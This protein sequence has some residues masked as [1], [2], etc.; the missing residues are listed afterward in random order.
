MRKMLAC[1]G[2]YPPL[3]FCSIISIWLL[4]AVSGIALCQTPDAALGTGDEKCSY[5]PEQ[6]MQLLSVLGDK[7]GYSYDSLLVDLSRWKQSPYVSIDSL[8]ATV[9]NR[10]LWELTIT[11]D[12]PAAVPRRTVYVHA[13]T[14]P[15]EVQAFWVTD[16][17]IKLLLSEDEFARFMRD[18]CTF[19]IIPMYNPDGVELEYPRQN[20]HRVDIES[21]WYANPVEPEVAVLRS[22]FAELMA[23]DAPVEVALNM[24]SDNNC[25]RF[26]VY[27]DAAGT[28]SAF[29]VLERQFIGGV[30]SYYPQG[31][32]PWYYFI[33]WTSGTPRRY[34][35]SWFWLNFQEQVM[36][37]TYED[38][39]CSAAS[40][41]DRTAYALLHGVADYLGLVVTSVIDV[42]ETLPDDFELRQ[43]YPNPVRL[44]RATTLSSVIQYSLQ[45]AQ[46]IRLVLYDILGRKIS[47]LDE[48]PKQATTHRVFLNASAL[49]AG[50]YYYRL[51]T[52]TG[53]R[54]RQ[55]TVMK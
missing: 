45:T 27:H 8:G 47:V 12:Y 38:M 25:R 54:T 37:L 36:A 55:L 30:R 52:T 9:Q 32:E 3:V 7:W 21:N 16:E 40:E 13:R 23:S 28:S 29:A 35:E 17:L 34:P 11:A 26:F 39:N 51:E 18:R 33:S 24:H 48:G 41:Y 50:T 19:Y 20:A 1:A 42:A 43:N 53:I 22:R 4:F 44:S 2:S 10:A 15:G 49:P 31:M 14:H 6:A 46:S 5:D